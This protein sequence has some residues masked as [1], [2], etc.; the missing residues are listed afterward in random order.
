MASLTVEPPSAFPWPPSRTVG[1]DV[2][3][4]AA[5]PPMEILIGLALSLSRQLMKLS[6]LD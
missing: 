4:T 6:L 3:R 5:Q 1:K 2:S